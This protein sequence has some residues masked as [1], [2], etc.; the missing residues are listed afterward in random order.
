M[1]EVKSKTNAET[2]MLS[3]RENASVF[4]IQT[5]F[6]LYK[7]EDYSYGIIENLIPTNVGKTTTQYDENGNVMFIDYQRDDNDDIIMEDYKI[8][9]VSGYNF[10]FPHL[11]ANYTSA[12]GLKNSFGWFNSFTN[13]EKSIVYNMGNDWTF[14]LDKIIDFDENDP[15][16]ISATLRSNNIRQGLRNETEVFFNSAVG[17]SAFYVTNNNAMFDYLSNV[18]D[19]NNDNFLKTKVNNEGNYFIEYEMAQ[20]SPIVNNNLAA[21]Y[22]MLYF[23]ND[24]SNSFVSEIYTIPQMESI[25]GIDLNKP[26][27][28]INK[29]E[30]RL[31]GVYYFNGVE[32]KLED[33]IALQTSIN[34]FLI[35]NPIKRNFNSWRDVILTTIKNRTDII[36][37]NIRYCNL[38]I[39]QLHVSGKSEYIIGDFIKLK[40]KNLEGLDTSLIKVGNNFTFGTPKTVI[41]P[42][43][44]MNDK[45][46]IDFPEKKYFIGD[47]LNSVEVTNFVSFKTNTKDKISFDIIC[48]GIIPDDLN[49]TQ[50][51]LVWKITGE[52][53]FNIFPQI[54]DTT[55]SNH[56]EWKR[57][58]NSADEYRYNSPYTFSENS[59]LCLNSADSFWPNGNE[60]FVGYSGTDESNKY[61]SLGSRYPL[62]QFGEVRFSIRK[63]FH[64]ETEARVLNDIFVINSKF[65]NYPQNVSVRYNGVASI[66]SYE[67]L[68]NSLTHDIQN[69]TLYP[70]MYDATKIRI[71]YTLK[72]GEEIDIA[73]S[74]ISLSINENTIDNKNLDGVSLV[75]IIDGTLGDWIFSE[76]LIKNVREKCYELNVYIVAKSIENLGFNDSTV[77]VSFKANDWYE[78][79]FNLK[80]LDYTITYPTNLPPYLIQGMPF[81]DQKTTESI[82]DETNDRARVD[83]YGSPYIENCLDFDKDIIFTNATPLY[84]CKASGFMP[85]G[86]GTEFLDVSSYLLDTKTDQRVPIEYTSSYEGLTH[87]KVLTSSTKTWYGGISDDYF[88]N[89][90]LY[91]YTQNIESSAVSARGY[92][93]KNSLELVAHVDYTFVSEGVERHDMI[94]IESI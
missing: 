13:A 5:P 65:L 64:I 47:H 27:S 10:M 46:L 52:T 48:E 75:S 81:T 84:K 2:L 93:A 32:K 88:S 63:I 7:M 1:A 42:E 56:N 94:T 29:I 68:D 69:V 66:G 90:D 50:D 71:G 20:F 30:F 86:L 22:D 16:D 35:N 31:Y 67:K 74:D 25:F 62:S 83:Y 3:D 28:M 23:K 17:E 70:Y 26:E 21:Y 82:L 14:N 61:F 58:L 59:G 44:L 73:N 55:G 45:F 18:Y 79:M 11:A 43:F 37:D 54:Y 72:G 80:G 36:V 38:S 57:Y 85:Y 87:F 60:P 6:D 92:L 39:K 12:F 4:N 91:T 41:K 19:E 89:F 15:E 8:L 49:I 34:D 9:A 78:K 40:L 53:T 51:E 77:S 76:G 24:P 33:D